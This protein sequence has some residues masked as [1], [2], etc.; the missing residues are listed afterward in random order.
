M[1]TTHQTPLI[2]PGSVLL[3][4]GGAKGITAQCVL[5]IA[6]H[7]PCSF[8]LAGRSALL[9]P[10]PNWAAGKSNT[11]LQA[12]ALDDFKK[13]GK[14][15]TPKE[16]QQ[17][18]NQVLS[19]REITATLGKMNQTGAKAVYISADVTDAEGLKT[20]VESAAKRLG[21][22][23]GIIHGAG[24]LADKSIENKS[25]R[26]FDLVVNTKIIGLQNIL[27]AVQP[28]ALKF[29]VLFSSV[30]G[31]FGNS[32]QA[33]YAIA[34]EVLNKSAYILQKSL[35]NCRVAA[36]NWGPWDSGMVS[37]DLKKVF[38]QRG[39]RLI[40]SQNG[41]SALLDELTRPDSLPQVVIGS[42]ILAE[43]KAA[44]PAGSTLTLRRRLALR[45]NPFLNDHRIGP[46]AVLPA[47]C[48]SAWLADA[49]QALHPG[50][51][52]SH[53][54]DFKILKGITFDESINEGVN[55]Y[56]LELKPAAAPDENKQVYDALITSQNEGSRKIFHYSGQVTLSK[57][58]PS[59]PRPASLA[60]LNKHDLQPKDAKEFYANGT[61]FHGPS[62]Q[63]IQ[64]VL[65][66]DEKQVVIKVM[67]P[68][69]SPQVQGQFP[70]RV[71][72]PFINDAIVQSL[73]IWTQTYYDA[74][75]L[76]SRLHQWEHYRLIP[77][78][79]PVWAFLEVT[80]HNQHAVVGN[81]SVQ[82]ENGSEYFRFTGLEGTVSQHLKRFIG[83]KA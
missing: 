56:I 44:L 63:G 3:V 30:A 60:A 23:T 54:E 64:Q 42:P 38:E 26:D 53:M 5:K 68:P 66:L 81:I 73:L 19:S 17:A 25:S 11:E 34:N 16:L 79:L 9:N 65:L 14:K 36:I 74:P 43:L 35:P 49:C 4:S 47:T 33:D 31:F 21:P 41:I 76:P 69:L 83:K 75:C 29:I 18:V 48:A 22:V 82:D 80:H 50:L 77:F 45:D 15:A 46:Q 61:L 57:Q 58:I 6:E 2:A 32:G 10:E 12:S 72:N 20:A 67:L 1:T 78:G 51:S 62:F 39:I 70:A 27:Q 59:A 37:D 55:E 52:F 28:Q 24:N 7:T 13:Q 71:T 8:I 40:D